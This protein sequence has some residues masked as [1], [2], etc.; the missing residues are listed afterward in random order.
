MKYEFDGETLSEKSVL[1]K[2]EETGFSNS[3][4]VLNRAVNFLKKYPDGEYRI[5]K[6]E[7]KLLKD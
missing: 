2:I 1:E 6:R 7:I 5:N 3:K 4:E